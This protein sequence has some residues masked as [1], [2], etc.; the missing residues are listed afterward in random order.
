MTEGDK[1]RL[2]GL[3]RRPSAGLPFYHVISCCFSPE[4]K[5]KKENGESSERKQWSWDGWN[6]SHTQAEMIQIPPG[7][8]QPEL[9]A[10]G[11]GGPWVLKPVEGKRKRKRKAAESFCRRL[12]VPSLSG[13]WKTNHEGRT[14]SS[15]TR[16]PK[17]VK[18]NLVLHVLGDDEVN[19]AGLRDKHSLRLLRA[20]F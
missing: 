4:E 11:S 2:F 13:G 17:S 9:C 10:S 14:I 5:K 15:G 19:T 6:G 7:V 20:D 16:P 12:L 1:R 18:S 3:F 8:L